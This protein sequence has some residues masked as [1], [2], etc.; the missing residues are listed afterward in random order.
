M[1][2]NKTNRQK[3]TLVGAICV[4]AVIMAGS[5][6]AWFTSKDEVTNRLTATA[7]YGVSIVEDFTPPEDM[8]PGQVV[9]KDVSVVN[10]G[11]VDAFV[12]LSFENAIDLSRLTSQDLSTAI[13]A[14]T[15]Y[16][17]T[18][19]GTTGNTNGTVS[20]DAY[21]D[22]TL[23]AGQTKMYNILT[24]G[25]PG[26]APTAATGTELI[27]LSAHETVNA[28]GTTTANEVTTLMAGGQ[29]VV[30]GSKSV[31]PGEQS[32]RSGDD[33]NGGFAVV[34]TNGAE[35][36]MLDTDGKYYEVVA[37]DN[38][39]YTKK[40]D[41]A[42]AN[43]P[44]GL[45]VAA[46]VRDY[47]GTGQYTPQDNGLYLFKR[48]VDITDNGTVVDDN[49]N[50]TY[51][52]FYYQGGTFYALATEQA[53][54]AGTKD[55]AKAD[56]I[57]VTYTNGVVSAISGVKLQ[58]KQKDLTVSDGTFTMSLTTTEGGTALTENYDTAKYMTVTYHVTADGNTSKDVI[59]YVKLADDWATN[60]TYVPGTVTNGTG[61]FYYN[62][63]LEGGKTSEKLVDSVKLA[64]TMTAAN[65]YELT[66]DLNV[67]LDSVQVTKDEQGN[68]TSDAVPDEWA[69]ETLTKS[70]GVITSVAW[71]AT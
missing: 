27:A 19:T 20:G 45:T 32:V 52:G 5:T 62:Y 22:P 18:D 69:N 1:T 46:L 21:T 55:T 61:Y 40:S 23:A 2:K 16:Y 36:Y 60:W 57:T 14:G 43:A 63:T 26:T 4:A 9:N 34:Y 25:T 44:T 12:R 53:D 7:N 11:A 39:L 56:G 38:G 28:D 10:T 37:D 64:D 49:A 48:S 15:T 70:G 68:E 54:S 35:S 58:S 47:S 13:T 50:G 59:F 8:T 31:A 71:S 51:S 30:A 41:T 66:Y 6:F 33:I 29:V 17:K 24:F 42:E 65:Y 3:R 67:L